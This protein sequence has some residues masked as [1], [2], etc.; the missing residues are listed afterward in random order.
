[1]ANLPPEENGP[2]RELRKHAAAQREAERQ[3]VFA[4]WNERLGG[5]P[6]PTKRV[7]RDHCK[8]LLDGP[9][10]IEGPYALYIFLILH[11]PQSKLPTSWTGL[12]ILKK[13]RLAQRVRRLLTRLA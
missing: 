1:M 9:H 3:R 12:S 5:K 11:A 13:Y 8:V 2:L 10:L 4:E 7:L 6:P